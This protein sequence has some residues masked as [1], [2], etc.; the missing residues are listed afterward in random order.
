METEVRTGRGRIDAVAA[1]ADTVYVFEF[2]LDGTADEALAQ[3]HAKRYFEPYLDDG[4]RITLIGVAFAQ[5]TRNLGEHRIETLTP[6]R[7]REAP[8]TYG[9][10][11]DG[12]SSTHETDIREIARRLKARGIAD[13][14]IQ[15]VTGL[16]P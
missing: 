3:I 2:K 10:A 12:E 9:T 13:A 8:A 5:A 16:T 11:T 7:L 6:G 1:T 4:R 15:D 14:I